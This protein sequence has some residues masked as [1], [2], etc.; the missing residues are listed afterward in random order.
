VLP[1][2][3]ANGHLDAIERISPQEAYRSVEQLIVDLGENL[4]RA[5]DRQ[6]YLSAALFQFWACDE[7]NRLQGN[8]NPDL[9]MIGGY[10]LRNYI[11]SAVLIEKQIASE[12]V[13]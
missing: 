2:E 4:T 13:A 9:K 12:K 3:R 5:D 6:T 10:L 7:L 8:D 11:A 1:A